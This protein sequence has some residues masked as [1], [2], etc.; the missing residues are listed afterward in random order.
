M[1]ATKEAIG[2]VLD[3]GPSMN[4]APPGEETPLQTAIAAIT[5]ILQRKM[6]AESKDEVC[7]VLF[8]TQNTDNPLANGDCYENIVVAR[9]LGIA[10]FDLLQM[11][12]NDITTSNVSADFV[13]ALIVALDQVINGMQGKRGFAH[14][15]LILFSDLGGE[16]GDDQIEKIIAGIR[17]TQTELN[18]IGPDFDDDGDDGDAGGAS[19]A[20]VNGQRKEKTPQQKVG[21]KMVKHILEEVNGECYSFNEALPALSYFQARQ[22]R[23]TAWKCNLEIGPNLKIPICGYIKVKDFKLK[24]SWKKVYAK[25]PQADVGLL[26]TSHMNDEEETEVEKEDIVE[27]Y[28]YGNTLVPMSSD[29]KE[30]MKYKSSKCFKVLGF[31]K[32]DNIKRHHYMGDG[33]SMVVADKGDDAAGVALSSLIN[34]L[35]ET[36]MVAIV[37]RVYMANSAPKL[38]FLSPKIKGSYECLMYTELPFMEDIR[39][40]T[41]GSLPVK[42]TENQTNKKYSPSAEQLRAIDDLITS[43]D[44]TAEDEDGEKNELLKPNLL[45]NPH[46]QRLYQCLQHRV[47]NPDDPLPELSPLVANYLKPPQEVITKCQ[48]NVEKVKT[49]FKL[50]VNTKKKEEQTGENMFKQNDEVEPGPVSK[51][52]KLDDS[53]EGGIADLT[54]AKVT[55]VG[56]VTPVEDFRTLIASKDEDLFE[57][58]CDQMSKRAE[59]IVLDSFGAHFYGKAMDCLKALRQECI[60]VQWWNL[61]S[62]HGLSE[63]TETGVYKGTVVGFGVQSW[64]V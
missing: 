1:A 63:G 56:S 62:S 54:K 21:E 12:Q 61:G 43:M 27:G 36:N 25:D 55:E 9:T 30:S 7:L 13:D 6:F 42:E 22:V 57:K 35:Y 41:F 47:L 5:M 29:D 58:A 15:R 19:V 52:A 4:Q 33:V 48:D 39:Q 60:K 26:R 20:V 14:K 17:N 10:D 64:I 32:S 8:G 59:E 16:F 44:L 40:F 23:P 46:F 24:Q 37:R 18:I 51:R 31:T 11:V 28:R 50:E 38:G 34:A 53:L 49:L 45:F 2:I 3:V